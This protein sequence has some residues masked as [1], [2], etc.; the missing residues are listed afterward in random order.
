MAIVNMLKL[1]NRKIANN[2]NWRGFQFLVWSDKK[3]QPLTISTSARVEKK[4]IIL[5]ECWNWKNGW[6]D[7]SSIQNFGSQFRVHPEF[8]P[9]RDE[10]VKLMKNEFKIE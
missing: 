10:V 5:Q 8:K 3:D 7:K 4:E 2:P 6:K 9:L 1:S